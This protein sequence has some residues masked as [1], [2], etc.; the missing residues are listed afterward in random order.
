MTKFEPTKEQQDVVNHN[1][2]AFVAACP[3]AGKTRCI[4]ERAG[5]T[6]NSST[7]V[8]ALAFLSFT[9]AA[10][11]ELQE[12]LLNEGVMPDP[13]FPHFIGTFDS[14]I[15]Q[16]MVG[17]FGLDGVDQSLRLIADKNQLLV[18]PF[19]TAQP[20]ALECF[21]RASGNII[22]DRA[23]LTG[24]RINANT[25][26]AYQ[27][28]AR[29]KRANLLQN[30]FLDF[31]DVRDVARDN[32]NDKA[33]SERLATILSARFSEVIV[34]EAQDC[35]L[36]DLSIIDWFRKDA[37]I[38]TKVICDPHQSIYGFRGG[39]TGELFAFGE[40][41]PPEQ[42]LPLNGNFRSSENICK[43]V[44][45]FR[46]PK[47]R[48]DVDQALGPFKNAKTPIHLL[49][50]KGAVCSD[51]GEKFSELA[52][53]NRIELRDCRLVAKTRSTGLKA[54]G[55]LNFN[56][57]QALVRRLAKAVL[58]YHSAASPNDA[59]EA[60][61]EVHLITLDLSGKL[62]GRTYHQ[63][64]TEEEI[65]PLRWRGE[66][67]DL[68]HALEFNADQGHTRKEWVSRAQASLKQFMVDPTAS[69]AQKVPNLSNLDELLQ[70][71]PIQGIATRTIHEVKGKQY[72]GICAV[73]TSNTAKGIMDNL[74]SK[75]EDA[76]EAT[77]EIYV[78]AS[79]A[80]R[81][82]IIACLNSQMSRLEAHLNSTGAAVVRHNLWE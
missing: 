43:A 24:F 4:V 11:A 1:G 36:S 26:A 5:K 81:M 33:F 67:V 14:F 44:H 72:P 27:T 15:W 20:L 69:I 10:V 25:I 51:I 23:R 16:Y 30:G 76:A 66:I 47:Y 31:D 22:E 19:P 71:T 40:T 62:D 77:R 73:M 79:R 55:S 49:A 37:G 65:E 60:L 13:V 50:Y 28:S 42:R 29:N 58:S 17:P 70:Q 39:V 64:L 38:S 53:D 35:N 75:S 80:E 78:A 41:F 63:C 45:F 18:Q 6:L 52:N 8:G 3:G 56:V 12:R 21:D 32:L 34:D 2:S 57:G 46:S 82:L 61:A 7:Y 54:I 74:E 68:I 59:N 48:G 9:N